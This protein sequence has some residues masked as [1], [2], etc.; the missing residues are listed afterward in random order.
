MAVGSGFAVGKEKLKVISPR[1]GGGRSCHK[2]P[3]HPLAIEWAPPANQL[4]KCSAMVTMNNPHP[5]RPANDRKAT[6]HRSKDNQFIGTR[7]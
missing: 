3:P 7:R 1:G 4:A 5:P 6:Q 2:L